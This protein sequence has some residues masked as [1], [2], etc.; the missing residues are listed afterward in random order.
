M[1]QQIISIFLLII[2][3]VCVIGT[4]LCFVAQGILL[5]SEYSAF[6]FKLYLYFFEHKEYKV[7]KEVKKLIKENRDNI[8]VCSSYT[9]T[10]N[11]QGYYFLVHDKYVSLW[12]DKNPVFVTF[13]QYIL[14]EFI[15]LGN[16]M[17]DILCI[18]EADDNKRKQMEERIKE[19]K[20]EIEEGKV[21][22]V[23]L[24]EQDNA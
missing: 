24:N 4:L 14:D 1:F 17:T 21:R 2:I 23:K 6:F 13:H 12:K 8:K 10:Y 11:M 18:R 16:Y 9:D 15:K 7:Y 19:L 22:L 20:K 3:A 5:F